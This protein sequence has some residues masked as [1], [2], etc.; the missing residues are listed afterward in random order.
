MAPSRRR[1]SKEKNASTEWVNRKK[2]EIQYRYAAFTQ[3]PGLKRGPSLPAGVFVRANQYSGM[4][5]RTT[6]TL[7]SGIRLVARLQTSNT[8][9]ALVTRHLRQRHRSDGGRACCARDNPSAQKERQRL[10]RLAR[11]DRPSNSNHAERA[12]AHQVQ[13][14]SGDRGDDVCADIDGPRLHG[15]GPV[16]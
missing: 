9:M 7:T 4:R 3:R 1:K 16:E 14:Q 2:E 12:A 10:Q 8:K 5:A 15:D 11:E 13:E 6:P